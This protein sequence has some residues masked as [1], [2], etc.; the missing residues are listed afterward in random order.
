MDPGEG[1]LPPP[2]PPPSSPALFLDQTEA[3]R[4]EKILGGDPLHPL[5][6]QPPYLKVWN[7][8]LRL[9][10]GELHILQNDSSLNLT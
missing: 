7:S 10:A 5:P 8:A 9:N 1:P 3:R 4:A 2:P 6:P